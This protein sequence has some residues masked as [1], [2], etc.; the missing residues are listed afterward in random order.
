VAVADIWKYNRNPVARRMEFENKHQVEGPVA[1]YEEVTEMLD[2]HPE[3]EAVF[4]ATPDHLHAPIA[5]AAMAAGKHVYVQKPLT[6]SVHEARRIRGLPS[7]QIEAVLG[8]LEE[9]EL[10]HRDN[11]VLIS[12]AEKR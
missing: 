8:F 2:K 7:T 4:I 9:P 5:L 10:I 12:S 11:L 6:Y 3:I 1:Q